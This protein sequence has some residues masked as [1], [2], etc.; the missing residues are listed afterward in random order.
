MH[1]VPVRIRR[2]VLVRY[3][4]RRDHIVKYFCTVIV[5]LAMNMRLWAVDYMVSLNDRMTPCGHKNRQDYKRELTH[6]QKLREFP[7][8]DSSFPCRTGYPQLSTDLG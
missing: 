7:R 1:T 4:N 6:V 2:L 5:V 3:G 8:F